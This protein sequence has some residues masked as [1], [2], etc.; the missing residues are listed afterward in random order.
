MSYSSF[1]TRYVVPKIYFAQFISWERSE[2]LEWYFPIYSFSLYKDY[3]SNGIF[4][5]I[6][7]QKYLSSFKEFF[8]W[9]EGKEFDE[10]LHFQY[11]SYFLDKQF[12]FLLSQWFNKNGFD[13]E[14]GTLQNLIEYITLSYSKEN[15][16]RVTA[17]FIF[18][19]I[20]HDID[21]FLR[22]ELFLP[23]RKS[24]NLLELQKD[25][26]LSNQDINKLSA[27]FDR[28]KAFFEWSK[29]FMESDNA[30]DIALKEDIQNSSLKIDE[31]FSALKNYEVYT[32]NYDVSKQNILG[33]DVFSDDDALILSEEN[34]REYL[35]QFSWVS[36]DG[37]SENSWWLLLWDI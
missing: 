8:K 30:R 26:T 16:D 10:K 19:G 9:E 1:E 3:D 27:E 7:Y 32:L 12:H 13:R 25:K 21:S 35:S 34:A 18:S 11:F 36:F 2:N 14:I 17:L 28:I 6:Y 5:T 29:V 15:T 37:M 24:G 23:Q 22:M 4:S 31:Y 33:L 20:L